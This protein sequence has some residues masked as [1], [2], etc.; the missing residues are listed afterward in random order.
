VQGLGGNAG[1]NLVEGFTSYSRE[2]AGSVVWMHIGKNRGQALQ[3]GCVTLDLVDAY[4][5]I[6]Q[7]DF[8]F[9]SFQVRGILKPKQRKDNPKEFE[10][11]VQADFKFQETFQIKHESP[12]LKTISA[13]KQVTANC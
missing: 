6:I 3:Y 7:R 8:C 2:V 9:E 10:C 12:K 11:R 4:A 13:A 1:R 5:D